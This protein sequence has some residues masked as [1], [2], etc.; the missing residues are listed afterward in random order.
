M[1][2]SAAR[3]AGLVFVRGV[4]ASSVRC[5]SGWGASVAGSGVRSVGPA[6]AR[7][8]W[9]PRTRSCARRDAVEVVGAALTAKARGVGHRRIAVD[10]GRHASTV[11]GWLRRVTVMAD[12]LREHFTR[13]AH[14]LDPSHDRVSLGG[15]AF[16]DAVEAIGVL[17]MV[18]VR[19][20]GPRPPWSLAAVVTGGGL[21]CNTSR[22][23]ARPV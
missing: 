8:S 6:P 11:R 17:G 9:F 4:T 3:A 14:A 13:W 1:A 18:A 7:T 23:W 12:E 15:S 20:F 19:R 16:R 2:V 10:L 22:L 5:A 21:L